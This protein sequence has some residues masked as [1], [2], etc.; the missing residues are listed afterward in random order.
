MRSP[1]VLL[2]LLGAVTAGCATDTPTTQDDPESAPIAPLEAQR[3]DDFRS[4]AS[5]GC[6]QLPMIRIGSCEATTHLTPIP[7]NETVTGFKG[8]I[9][10]S[11]LLSTG[12]VDPV[13][14][15]TIWSAPESRREARPTM[16]ASIE[17]TLPL[18]LAAE[19]LD[20][21]TGVDLEH[22]FSLPD[23]IVG[24]KFHAL[25]GNLTAEVLRF[26]STRTA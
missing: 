16:I 12:G 15:W 26:P 19:N 7:A 2:L 23:A 21:P 24:H 13:V 10:A 11:T 8:T 4:A 6:T 9:D 14:N 3:H 1:L 25:Q 22:H 20:L 17:G 18:E 5:G